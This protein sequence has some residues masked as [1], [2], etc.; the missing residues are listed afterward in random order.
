VPIDPVPWLDQRELRAWRGFHDMRTQLLSQLARQLQTDSGLSEA[1]FEVL[2]HVSEAPSQRIRAVDLGRRLGWEKSR[3][4]KQVSRM[5]NRGLVRREL[6][7]NDRR[8]ADIV[9]T[10][11]GKRAIKEAAPQHTV[12]IRRLFI[13]P[14]TPKQLDALAEI[15]EAII[16]NLERL[17]RE[18]KDS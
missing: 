11:Q 3:L 1:D 2:V 17:E 16:D 18:V 7:E 10:A 8:G 5:Q 9:L 13:D 4:S 14:L 12:E 6:C 15:S